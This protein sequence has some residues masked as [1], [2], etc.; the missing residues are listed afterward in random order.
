MDITAIMN[1]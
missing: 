1:E